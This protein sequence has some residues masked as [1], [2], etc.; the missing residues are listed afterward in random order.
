MQL[1]PSRMRPGML[2]PFRLL[3]TSQ[4]PRLTVTV[5]RHRASLLVMSVYCRMPWSVI[6][7]HRDIPPFTKVSVLFFSSRQ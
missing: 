3:S 7:S 4:Y 2:L 6:H 1:T 5:D